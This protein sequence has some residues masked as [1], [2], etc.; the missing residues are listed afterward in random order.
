VS[1]AA[2]PSAPSL[3]SLFTS[4]GP[5]LRHLFTRGNALPL[6][7]GT[8]GS[9]TAHHWDQGVATAHWGEDAGE[10]MT[11]GSFAGSLAIQQGGAFAVYSIGRLTHRPGV[12]TLG[13]DLFRAGL[14][15]Q[16]TTQAIKFT[17]RR[18]R[19]DGSSL[20]FPSGHTAS[21]FATATVLQSRF[22]WK[23]GLPAYAMASWVGAARMETN[24]HYLSDVIAGAT[25]GILSGRTVTLGKG[26]A[27]FEMSP[28]V[29]PHG[30]VG[31][32]FTKKN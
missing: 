7:V 2:S 30:G 16:T 28:M 25:I 18:V 31:V 17:A 14:L 12:A 13:A 32:G 8:A 19:P 9:L 20:S 26:A 24:R 29:G 6:I 27:R 3:P 22:G 1:A 23:V 10:T 5:D 21:A 15:A 11:H 4:I